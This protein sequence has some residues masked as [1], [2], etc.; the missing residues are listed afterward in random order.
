MLHICAVLFILVS[1]TVGVEYDDLNCPINSYSQ[2]YWTNKYLTRMQIIGTWVGR[3]VFYSVDP[4]TL[5]V[6]TLFWTDATLFQLYDAGQGT[7][8]TTFYIRY[9][10]PNN[11]TGV[12]QGVGMPAGNFTSYV[13]RFERPDRLC[14]IANNTA[15]FEAYYSE[16]NFYSTS[17]ETN[18][19]YNKTTQRVAVHEVFRYPINY[20]PTVNK[21]V[22][23]YQ[24][25]D[26]D[27][28]SLVLWNAY[29][30]CKVSNGITSFNPATTDQWPT[31]CGVVN[32]PPAPKPPK[33][34]KP[35]H[36]PHHHHKRDIEES[37]Q[38]I[39]LYMIGN[40]LVR[41]TDLPENL[42]RYATLV[43]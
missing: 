19:H 11:N 1:Y 17:V 37:E 22:T 27:S 9:V 41:E 7:T 36:P 33:T 40:G 2:S 13:D 30:L 18:T 34:P 10:Q 39:K 3:G 14:L 43:E 32:S 25:Y 6:T 31:V 20:N 21:M 5:V 35:P 12:G 42:K 4:N 28:N 15:Q 23:T 8:V 24:L 26:D 29:N 16:A 38:K